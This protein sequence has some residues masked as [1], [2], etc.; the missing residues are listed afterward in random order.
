[1]AVLAIRLGAPIPGGSSALGRSCLRK[2]S[3]TV[4]IRR[5]VMDVRDRVP[6]GYCDLTESAV[7]PTEL[8][9]PD[10]FGIICSGDP[11]WLP[12]R[13]TTPLSFI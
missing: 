8:Q 4:D 11:L 13:R 12:K 5:E 1:M 3:G 10:N 6:A 7:I 2:Y 9:S